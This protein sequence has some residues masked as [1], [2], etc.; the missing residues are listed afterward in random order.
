MTGRGGSWAGGRLRPRLSNAGGRVRKRPPGFLPPRRC[1]SSAR[2]RSART[3]ARAGV[4]REDGDPG[5]ELAAAL[6][7]RPGGRGG[8]IRALSGRRAAGG[9]QHGLQP[10][11][12]PENEQENRPAHQGKSAAAG[13]ARRG[14][15]V[16][17]DGLSCQAGRLRASRPGR[18]EGGFCG[19]ATARD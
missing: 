4:Y 16:G 1:C 17:R 15:H 10:G 9:A 7:R 6:L 13:S 11:P 12:A 14:P 8:Q 18:V 5:H 19:E 2:P 3:G